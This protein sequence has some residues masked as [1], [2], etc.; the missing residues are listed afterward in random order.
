[1]TTLCGSIPGEALGIID[2]GEPQFDYEGVDFLAIRILNG[3]SNWITNLKP[4]DWST[5]PWYGSLIEFVELLRR[6]VS[7]PKLQREGEKLSSLFSSF[8]DLRTKSS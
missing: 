1:L 4:E 2:E 3:L 5:Q 7:F 8:F 6:Q